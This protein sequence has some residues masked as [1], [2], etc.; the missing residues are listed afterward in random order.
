MFNHRGVILFFTGI[1]SIPFLYAQPYQFSIEMVDKTGKSTQIELD[2]NA[3]LQR[4]TLLSK[5]MITTLNLN[6]EKKLQ[7]IYPLYQQLKQQDDVLLLWSDAMLAKS[8]GD[9]EQGI[10]LYEKL[11]QKQPN[12]SPAKLQLA[13]LFVEQNN[14]KQAQDLFKQVQISERSDYQRIAQFYLNS[15]EPKKWHYD[16]SLS[17]LNEK[18]INQVV[19]KGTKIEHLKT[20]QAPEN[21]QGF[22]YSGRIAKDLVKK[23]YF[24]D[25]A[26]TTSGK[27][28]WNNHKY[29]E[30]NLNFSS[31]IGR[32]YQKTKWQIT[33]FVEQFFYAGGEDKNT[34]LKPNYFGYGSQFKADYYFTKSLSLSSFVHYEQQKY[35]KEKQFNSDIYQ[36][37]LSVGYQLPDFYF[38]LGTNYKIKES[39]TEHNSFDQ[40]QINTNLVK[41][42]K[43]GLV[44]RVYLSYLDRHY[45]KARSQ[46]KSVFI[47]SFYRKPQKDKEYTASLTLWHN[48][49]NFKGITPKLTFEYKK[50]HSNNLFKNHSKKQVYL[51]LSKY[52]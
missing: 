14:Q 28:F 1:F 26:L 24:V 22:S 29:D 50:L 11:L 46:S 32:R 49:L 8:Q 13:L 48:N 35:N 3:L 15:D 7:S 31:T 16:F 34:H 19:P 51:T 52:F 37:G 36:V 10:A 43:F 44:S 40:L 18:N 5:I 12:L 45:D 38:N 2:E 41:A 27:Y 30:L 6:D 23:P 20:I 42:F 9:I 17:Y 25:L 4:P 39:D 33:P 47:P 21:A